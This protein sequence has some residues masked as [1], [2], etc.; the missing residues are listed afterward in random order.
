RNRRGLARTRHTKETALDRAPSRE[1]RASCVCH[2][3]RARSAIATAASV[4][5]A[6][7]PH[8]AAAHLLIKSLRGRAKTVPG[9]TEA[10]VVAIEIVVALVLILA[11][12]VVVRL[13]IDPLTV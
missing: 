8:S 12:A 11:G 10:P 6:V 13:L 1:R 2:G 3:E 7:A 9:V 5:V 4:G